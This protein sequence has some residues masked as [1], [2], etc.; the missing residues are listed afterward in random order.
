MYG[1]EVKYLHKPYKSHINQQTKNSPK[2]V[3]K[4]T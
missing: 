2:T 4:Q 1:L 3:L